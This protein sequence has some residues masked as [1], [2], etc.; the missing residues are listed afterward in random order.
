MNRLQKAIFAGL[1][2]GTVVGFLTH[3]HGEIGDIV[4]SLCLARALLA[5]LPLYN[6]VCPINPGIAHDALPAAI[7]LLPFSFL[8]DF[9]ATILWNSLAFGTLAGALVYHRG[10]WSLVALLSYPAYQCWFYVQWYPFLAA[11]ALIPALLPIFIGKPHIA[12]VIGVWKYSHRL[13]AI[14]A[15]IFLLTVLCWPT[16]LVEWTKQARAYTSTDH[17]FV[18]LL[19]MP[20]L[21]CLPL[22]LLWRKT[23]ARLVLLFAIT[24]IRGCYNLLPIFVIAQSRKEMI[25]LS[26]MSWAA[27]IVSVQ[28]DSWQIAILLCNFAPVLLLFTN[29]FLNAYRENTLYLKRLMFQFLP[30]GRAKTETQ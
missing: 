27:P 19:T 25:W 7:T 14:C 16:W 18:M 15:G 4:N 6:G 29:D 23:R 28:A 26:I 20:G 24:P 13:A 3:L 2:V 12:F 22:L 30:V 1:V 17:G 10:G 11:A 8:S 9:W 5:G 21:V